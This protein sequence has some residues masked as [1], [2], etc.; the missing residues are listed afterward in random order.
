VH[1]TSVNLLI[2]EHSVQVAVNQQLSRDGREGVGDSAPSSST[3]TLMGLLR[4]GP[5]TEHGCPLPE[6]NQWTERRVVC[7]SQYLM[8]RL[9]LLIA[10]NAAAIFTV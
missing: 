4:W 9:E 7:D 10:D 2:I 5:G 6:M 1:R 8:E 3:A